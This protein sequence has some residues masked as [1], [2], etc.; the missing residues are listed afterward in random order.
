MFADPF[1]ITLPTAGAKSFARISS[2]GKS[3]VYVTSDGLFTLTI[4]HTEFTKNKVPYIK[5]MAKLEQKKLVT[6]LT[7]A[8]TDYQ[9]FTTHTVEERPFQGFTSAEMKDQ[10]S[11]LSTWLNLS[12]TQDKILQQES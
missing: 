10:M 6:S 11:G 12:G 7:D 3:S 1:T 5:S 4:S 8:S 9:T 2:Q